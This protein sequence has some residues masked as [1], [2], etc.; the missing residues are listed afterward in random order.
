M[1][2]KR[3]YIWAIIIMAISAMFWPF[4]VT[5][6]IF[7]ASIL[8][9]DNFYPGVII[10]FVMDAVYSYESHTVG[11]FWGALTIYGLFFYI[12]LELIKEKTSI[13]KR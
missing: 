5:I 13:I 1:G 12:I 7:A 10:L 2:N 9:I 8:L 4:W 3:L 11:P 6:L